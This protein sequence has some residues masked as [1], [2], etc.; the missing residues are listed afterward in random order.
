MKEGHRHPDGED[1]VL[2]SEALTRTKS[3]I[4]SVA[5]LLT[6]PKVQEAEQ[7]SKEAIEDGGRR[8]E[9][10]HEDDAKHLRSVDHNA[11]CPQVETLVLGETCHPTMGGRSEFAHE[12]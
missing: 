4:T 12:E 8:I 3:V 2:L 6:Y 9:Q 7:C 10:P 5:E 11:E 1:G